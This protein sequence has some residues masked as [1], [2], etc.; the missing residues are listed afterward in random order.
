MNSGYKRLFKKIYI[1]ILKIYSMSINRVSVCDIPLEFLKNKNPSRKIT[2]PY[3]PTDN[4]SIEKH[5]IRESSRYTWKQTHSHLYKLYSTR[6]IYFR[7][8]NQSNN[9][10][11]HIYMSLYIHVLFHTIR[12]EKIENKRVL[13]TPA[14]DLLL[15]WDLCIPRRMREGEKNKKERK[16]GRIIK[17]KEKKKKTRK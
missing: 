8:R 9:L 16:K 12:R 11:I 14:T 13:E 17:R 2:K 7:A 4:P 1:Y 5:R 6:S 10:Y 3:L 15:L